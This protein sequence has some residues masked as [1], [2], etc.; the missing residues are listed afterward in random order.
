MQLYSNC[1]VLNA[2]G[3]CFLYTN[4]GLTVVAVDGRYSNGTNC[5]TVSGGLG[6]ITGFQSCVADTT[7]EVFYSDISC[8]GTNLTVQKNGSTVIN[9]SD[10]NNGSFTANNGDV[11][12]ILSTAGS[13]KVGCNVVYLEVIDSVLGVLYSQDNVGVGGNLS[14]TFTIGVNTSGNITID[15]NA[16]GL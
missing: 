4:P 12:Y 13:G 2:S 1:S 3:S 9:Y 8:T 5:F 6:L 10:T 7:I 14:T 11:I 16:G 15:S